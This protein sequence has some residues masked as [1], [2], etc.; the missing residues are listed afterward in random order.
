[1]PTPEE[2]IEI[3]R[4]SGCSPNV[5]R[6]CRAVAEIAVK[7]ALKCRERGIPVDLE[8]IRIGALLHDLGRSKTHSVHHPVVG[9]KIAEELGLPEA[10]IRI[11]KRHIGGGL[12]AEEAAELGWPVEN[13]LPETLEEKI[14][15]YADKLIDG[16]K[17]VP[18]EKTIEEF[19]R[20]LG[21]D[22]PSI[23]RIMN[24]HREIM[25]L[26]GGSIE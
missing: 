13:Y 20:K 2:A 21:E 26:C 16:D 1:M 3:L 18:I 11:I 6:H 4:E 17:V 19:K 24:L 23:K 15:T 7:I 10:I 5:I 25:E 12:T 14:V 22:H 8:L 9:A